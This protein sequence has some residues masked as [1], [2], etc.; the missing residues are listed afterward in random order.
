M[1]GGGE[2]MRFSLNFSPIGLNVFEALQGFRFQ[3][4]LSKGGTFIIE[5]LSTGFDFVRQSVTPDKYPP[6]DSKWME[7]LEA[8]LFI[9]QRTSCLL[10]CPEN[11][12]YEDGQNVFAAR[13]I[14][15]SGR[16]QVVGEPWETKP[17]SREQA[18][19]LLKDLGD[20]QP[21]ELVVHYE[22]NAIIDLFHTRVPLGPAVY[23][24]KDAYMTD[25]DLL[26]LQ[27]A[28]E[29]AEYEETFTARITPTEGQLFDV[30]YVHWLPIDEKA[31]VLR[32]PMFRVGT[33]QN[34][35]R[36]L[37]HETSTDS[38]HFSSFI[39]ALS[40][41]RSHVVDNNSTLESQLNPFLDATD[42]E[43]RLSLEPILLD[44]DEESRIRLVE[45]IQ[46]AN[47]ISEAAVEQLK[48]L[49]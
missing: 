47:L 27:M 20:R 2:K 5:S 19:R 7:L 29:T 15:Q 46:Q 41:T 1:Q 49:P 11:V 40:E 33:L 39:A 6:P 31:V 16:I 37:W 25:E 26:K 12:S 44:L 34:A 9:Q 32:S 10:N 42:E 36:V 28:L 18:E 35:A 13:H 14:L 48:Q 17:L 38:D 22:T 24:C 3:S 4:A 8:L 43:M 30:V 45:I 23:S 21:R